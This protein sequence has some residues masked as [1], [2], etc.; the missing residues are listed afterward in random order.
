MNEQNL[1]YLEKNLKYLGFG[2]KLNAQFRAQL[3]LGL[4]EFKLST[5]SSFSDNKLKAELYFRKSEN[6]EM[7]FF[8]RYSASLTNE[9]EKTLREQTFY[10][11]HCASDIT[12]KEAFNLLE[13]RSV[14]KEMTNKDGQKYHAWLQLDFDN[15][16]Q[17]GNNELK[18]YHQN[19]GFDL[20][21]T[22]AKYPIRD[23]QEEE[24]KK[25]LLTSLY[26]GNLAGI[27]VDNYGKEEKVFI[28]ANP[29]MKAINVYDSEMKKIFQREM[30]MENKQELGQEL[31]KELTPENKQEQKKE[32]TSELK[33][34]NKNTSKKLAKEDDLEKKLGKK[35][36]ARD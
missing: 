22:L 36:P 20:E 32:L 18:Q 11:N 28:S 23:L 29:Q 25:M 9:R 6:S 12:L 1:E 24:S 17:H 35:N 15:Q 27:I 31:K 26:K 21:K 3:Q 14:H 10:V 33:P 30:K 19:Y 4:S 2:D 13:G 16:N 7:Y 8:N 34:E 5:E